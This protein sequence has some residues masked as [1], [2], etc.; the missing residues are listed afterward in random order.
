M[1]LAAFMRTALYDGTAGY[2]VLVHGEPL[3]AAA[4]GGA[5]GDQSPDGVVGDVMSTD[6]LSVAS[7]DTVRAAVA[8]MVR[9]GVHRV[10]V[11]DAGEKLVG[12]LST[13]DVLRGLVPELGDAPREVDGF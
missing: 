3:L 10:L 7:G 8:L 1:T 4:I 5:E 9:R 2:Y 12:V 13:M 11:C 6:V